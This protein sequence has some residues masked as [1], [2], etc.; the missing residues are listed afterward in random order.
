MLAIVTSSISTLGGWPLSEPIPGP[1]I[2][3]GRRYVKVFRSRS[4]GIIN[5]V[6]GRASLVFVQEARLLQG[7]MRPD[8][9]KGRAEDQRSGK[10]CTSQCTPAAPA[11][12]ENQAT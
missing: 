2:E 4:P 7:L 5:P 6:D 9:G 1:P 11:D 8:R 3:P 12:K 10:Q